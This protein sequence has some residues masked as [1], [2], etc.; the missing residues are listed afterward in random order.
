MPDGRE[1]AAI[2][3][4]TGIDEVPAAAWD[5]CARDSNPFV[6]HA[7]LSALEGSGSVGEDAG[8]LPQH[9][10]YHD[11]EGRLLGCLPLYLKSHSYG[12]YVFDWAWADA[13]ERAGGRYYPKLQSSVPFT[14]VTGPRLLVHP[15]A[16][17]RQT[18]QQSALVVVI[19]QV[20]RQPAGLLTDRAAILQGSQ[21]GMADEG[22]VGP[23]ASV[24]GRR[25]HLVDPGQDLDGSCLTSIRHALACSSCLSPQLDRRPSCLRGK[26]RSGS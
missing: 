11:D 14:P 25:R 13:Y 22:I 26:R 20:L 9:L 17:W 5:A 23:G 12:E 15:E 6:S 8:W 1:P 3:V 2:K 4:L 10:A 24:P 21:K 18:A 7:F 19:D 16:D